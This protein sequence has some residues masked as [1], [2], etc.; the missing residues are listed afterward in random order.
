MTDEVLPLN[1]T[2]I[3]YAVKTK[4][5][6]RNRYTKDIGVQ[7]EGEDYGMFGFGAGPSHCNH[8]LIIVSDAFT[9]SLQT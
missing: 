8:K 3:L 2:F 1:K 4:E 9:R 6:R 7:I 5:H